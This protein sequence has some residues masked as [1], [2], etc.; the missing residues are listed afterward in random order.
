MLEERIM[1]VVQKQYGHRHAS[2][3]R[4][5]H[6]LNREFEDDVSEADVASAVERLVSAGRLHKSVYYG[7]D[8]A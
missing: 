5:T 4:I 3:G 2:V 6:D 1:E 7:A 8:K